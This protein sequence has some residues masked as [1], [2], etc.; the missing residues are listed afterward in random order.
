MGVPG[1][2]VVDAG[3]LPVTPNANLNA[4]IV[5]VGEKGAADIAADWGVV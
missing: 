5:L 3:V 1:L 4:P 2:R